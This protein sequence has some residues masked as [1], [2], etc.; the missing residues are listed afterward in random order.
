LHRLSFFLRLRKAYRCE[1]VV[2]CDSNETLQE[3]S[4][5][6]LKNSRQIEFESCFESSKILLSTVALEIE[7]RFNL[8]SKHSELLSHKAV[9]YRNPAQ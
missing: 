5:F 9:S 6:L 4:I 7:S 2:A 3:L 1:C 8:L